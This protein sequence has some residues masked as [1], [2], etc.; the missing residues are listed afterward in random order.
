MHKIDAA[1]HA[2]SMLRLAIEYK[3]NQLNLSDSK[4]KDRM[5]FAYIRA[6]QAF[7]RDLCLYFNNKN[8]VRK[9]L[10]ILKERKL[11]PFGIDWSN[12]RIDKK[13]SLKN[14]ILNWMFALISIEPIFWIQ[15]F[16][17]GILFKN[18]RNNQKFDVSV[19]ADLLINT[20]T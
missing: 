11:Y 9:I 1:S 7:C 14:D 13:Q 3:K 2:Y 20:K 12:F 6:M 5:A 8:S 16:L 10:V 18:M 15:W 4:I 19:F 17:C